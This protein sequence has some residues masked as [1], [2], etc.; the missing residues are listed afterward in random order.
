MTARRSRRGA[1][2]VTQRAHGAGSHSLRPH[3]ATSA[4]VRLRAGP[5]RRGGGPSASGVSSSGPSTVEVKRRATAR[6]ASRVGGGPEDPARRSSTGAVPK[7]RPAS[8]WDVG[9]DRSGR[10]TSSAK[11]QVACRREAGDEGL[12]AAE[13]PPELRGCARSRIC[14]AV[15]QTGRG[16][17]PGWA[18]PLERP[19]PS[20]GWAA[21][22][23]P[24]R[25]AL[26]MGRAAGP[27]QPRCG[28]RAVWRHS[29][30]GTAPSS[31]VTSG[32]P[33]PSRARRRVAVPGSTLALSSVRAR[34]PVSLSR[35]RPPSPVLAR[36]ALPPVLLRPARP[37]GTGGTPGCR[38]G[39]T[40]CVRRSRCH[41]EACRRRPRRL[42]LLARARARRPGRRSQN[43][44]MM[45]TQT[46]LGRCLTS[47]SGVFRQS[48]NA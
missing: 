23:T 28:T 8:D 18:E 12:R 41:S 25:G 40:H 46:T 33:D 34:C 11:P 32:D 9:S 6:P 22:S 16:L 31:R 45:R 29:A 39:A 1:R 35:S 5:G 20:G 30:A 14:E 15:D 7:S 26:R 37:S 48:M 13:P 24:S 17:G 10:S 43:S 27:G 4:A 2:R 3:P 36:I 47:S 21:T 38:P 44:R 42:P 19:R